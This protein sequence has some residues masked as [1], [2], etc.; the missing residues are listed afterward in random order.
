MSEWQPIETVP[1]MRNVLMWAATDIGDDGTIKN[2]KMATGWWSDGHGTWVWDGH[3]IKS[4]NVKPTHWMEL[5][6]PPTLT[7]PEGRCQS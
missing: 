7:S 3:P 4:Y 2:W 5:P 6:E 1:S